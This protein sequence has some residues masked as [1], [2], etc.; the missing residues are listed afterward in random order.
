[1]SHNTIQRQTV[2]DARL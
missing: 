2:G 1:M